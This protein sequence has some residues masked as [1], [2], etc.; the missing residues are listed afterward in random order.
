MRK[1]PGTQ[2]GP[3][4]V[5]SSEWTRETAIE[6]WTPE[7]GSRE[8]AE[9]ILDV[10]AADAWFEFDDLGRMLLTTGDREVPGDILDR[11][12]HHREGLVRWFTQ[13]QA[14][15]RTRYEPLEAARG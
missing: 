14:E 5:D 11:L 13:W 3:V 2:A 10:I 9:L 12:R 7:A 15:N 1:R 8:V 6:S 4:L